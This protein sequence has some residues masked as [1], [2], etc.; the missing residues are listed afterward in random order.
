[1]KMIAGPIALV[2]LG[3]LVTFKFYDF[4]A[5]EL[6][7][8]GPVLPRLGLA[9][10]VGVGMSIAGAGLVTSGWASASIERIRTNQLA[11]AFFT[12]NLNTARIVR[13]GGATM[14]AFGGGMVL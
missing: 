13:A 9:T 4:L 14:T 8:L 11:S 6:E 12:S 5:G 1:M 7:A 2:V 10:P 3:L